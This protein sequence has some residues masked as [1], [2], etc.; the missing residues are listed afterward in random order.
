MLATVFNETDAYE[1]QF[2]RKLP[3]KDKLVRSDQLKL[4]HRA[5]FAASTSPFLGNSVCDI[6]SPIFTAC[7]CL[8]DA[9]I[10]FSLE[11]SA[12]RR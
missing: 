7:C 3:H 10:I 5:I 4:A 8:L 6:C 2:Q 1:K 11:S 9:A 12:G